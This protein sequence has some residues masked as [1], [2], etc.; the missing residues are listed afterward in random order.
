MNGSC[1]LASS[2]REELT[3]FCNEAVLGV[4][5][6][7]PCELTRTMHRGRSSVFE[8]AEWFN[9]TGEFDDLLIVFGDDDNKPPELKMFVQRG[10]GVVDCVRPRLLVGGR[11]TP[12]WRE[13]VSRMEEDPALRFVQ[14]R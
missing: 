4:P 6:D 9:G 3:S 7:D 1:T 8:T 2:A 11:A 10:D 5:S 14:P 13:H 12:A